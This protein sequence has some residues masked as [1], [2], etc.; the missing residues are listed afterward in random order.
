M[1][2]NCDNML[3]FGREQSKAISRHCLGILAVILK[4]L[5]G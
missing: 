1:I 5:R 4:R 3:G 2:I